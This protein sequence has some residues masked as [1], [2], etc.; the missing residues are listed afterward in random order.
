[1]AVVHDHDSARLT[2]DGIKGARAPVR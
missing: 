1:M 2:K